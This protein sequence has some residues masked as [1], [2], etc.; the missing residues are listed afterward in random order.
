M[1][2]KHISSHKRKACMEGPQQTVKLTDI[3]S[4]LEAD[5]SEIKALSYIL[6]FG[7]SYKKVAKDCNDLK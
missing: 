7:L 4:Y 1:C 2:I 5:N 6:Y 3:T